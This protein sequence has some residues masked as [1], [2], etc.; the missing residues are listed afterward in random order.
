MSIT[1]VRTYSPSFKD[2]KLFSYFKIAAYQILLLSYLIGL[3]NCTQSGP[4]TSEVQPLSVAVAA[5][6]QFAIEDIKVAFF[7]KYDI[8]VNL[9]VGSSGK[10]TAQIQQGAPYDLFISA[11][12]KYPESLYQDSLTVGPPKVYAL[13]ALVWWTMK[14]FDLQD[15]MP[16]VK[17][18]TIKKI[19]IANPKN[20][21]YGEEAI[22]ALEQL[23]LLSI[24]RKKLVYGE[25]IAQTNQYIISEVCDIGITAKSIVLSP[26]W[27]D[28]G[29]WLEIDAR[30]Y[31]PIQQGIVI[32]KVGQKRQPEMAQRF[33][34]FIFSE[35]GRKILAKYG[36]VLVPNEN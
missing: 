35:E 6:V 29:R 23:G 15:T 22:S 24:V 5:N 26:D 1:Y 11:N 16:I 18:T 13:G 2:M 34:D 7:Q 31:Q 32:T 8:P 12:M 21:P 9:M 25:S 36:Y 4:N 14:S 3:T 28:K 30:L 19:A 20:A 17:S 27:K 10:L 33:F